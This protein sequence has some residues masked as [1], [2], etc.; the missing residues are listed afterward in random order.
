M[1]QSYKKVKSGFNKCLSSQKNIMTMESCVN[2]IGTKFNV[3]LFTVGKENML[4]KY[5][6]IKTVR[7]KS[8]SKLD[9]NQFWMLDFFDVVFELVLAGP[10]V[11]V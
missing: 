3:C 2:N 10:P 1:K 8:K 11:I 5:G 6:F 7:I 9:S 4:R